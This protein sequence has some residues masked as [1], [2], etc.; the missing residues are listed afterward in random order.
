ML[1]FRRLLCISVLVYRVYTRLNLRFCSLWIVRPPFCS[2]LLWG[3]HDAVRCSRGANE[4]IQVLA[5][6]VPPPIA[7]LAPKRLLS[8]LPEGQS[9]PQTRSPLLR[10]RQ[11]ATSPPSF[12]SDRDQ[13][14]RFE[15]AQIPRQSAP[16][17]AHELGQCGNGQG[18]V[19]R[20][21]NQDGKLGGSKPYRAQRLV[22]GAG[23][24]ARRRSY[25]VAGAVGEDLPLRDHDQHP[26]SCIYTTRPRPVNATPRQRRVF[27]HTASSAA[28]ACAASRAGSRAGSPRAMPHSVPMPSIRAWRRAA[29]RRAASPAAS[30]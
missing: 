9:F 23:H 16:I 17:H 21:G 26:I 20:R 27:S 19:G 12:E 30:L 25:P 24:G 15:R 6:D 1:L 28:R 2:L 3:H 13:S 14:V 22:V 7:Q 4:I 10:N 18:I 5:D 8:L 11:G 29:A